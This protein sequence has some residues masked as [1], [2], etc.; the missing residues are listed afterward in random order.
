MSGAQSFADGCYLLAALL[1]PA[2]LVGMALV[3]RQDATKRTR[4]HRGGHGACASGSSARH[5]GSSKMASRALLLWRTYR[6]VPHCAL[7]C[8]VGQLYDAD[9]DRTPSREQGS[10]AAHPQFSNNF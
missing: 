2:V 9:T 1:K 10:S 5:L 6:H 3:W 7:R 4:A 8:A